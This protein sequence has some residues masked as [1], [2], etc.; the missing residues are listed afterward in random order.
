MTQQDRAA[1]RPPQTKVKHT[2]LA[3]YLAAWGG[4]I[5]S[6][7]RRQQPSK[8]Y[9]HLHFVYVDCHP[10][11]GTYQ[12]DLDEVMQGKPLTLIPWSPLLGIRSLDGL[13]QQALRDDLAVQVNAILIEEHPERASALWAALV[14]GMVSVV[15]SF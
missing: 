11:S 15:L 5:L 12:G 8:R 6:W 9:G 2:I 10:S 1:A 3:R 13:K 14:I 7:R 4:I